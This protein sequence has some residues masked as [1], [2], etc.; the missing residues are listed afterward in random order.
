MEQI[1]GTWRLISWTRLVGETEEVGPL[2]PDA[3]GFIIYSADGYMCANVMRPNRPKITTSD[4]G[5][6]PAEEKAAAFET[7]F[8]YCGRYDVAESEGFVTHSVE[9]S[10][11]PNLTGTAQKRFVTFVGDRMK[12]TTPPASSGGKQVSHVMLWERASLTPR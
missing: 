1:I 4:F 11:F 5:R 3:I 12:I 7:Y 2:G 9:V 6:A 10:S 8:S